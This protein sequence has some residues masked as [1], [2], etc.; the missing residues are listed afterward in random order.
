MDYG[1][2]EPENLITLCA[3][4]HAEWHM[5]EMAATL[6]FETWLELPP[7]L[8]LLSLYMSDTN[9]QVSLADAR[10]A[11]RRAHELRRSLGW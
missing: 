4:C 10:E 7:Y 8:F 1:S 5:V 11:T 6:A 2:N 3:V 9:I